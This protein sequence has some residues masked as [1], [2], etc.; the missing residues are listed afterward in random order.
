MVRGE[1]VRPGKARPRHDKYEHKTNAKLHKSNFEIIPDKFENN[2][3]FWKNILFSLEKMR[4][5]QLNHFCRATLDC[6][7]LPVFVTSGRPMERDQSGSG[8]SFPSRAS[9]GRPHSLTLLTFLQGVLTGI[10]YN[11]LRPLDMAHDKRDRT[12]LRG[13]IKP[14]K[15]IPFNYKD[16][17]PDLFV[18]SHSVIES[19]ELYI[20]D[21]SGSSISS[22]DCSINMKTKLN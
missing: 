14:L 22:L 8:A 17:N 3:K 18:D 6:V 9:S 21:G 4:K 16:L 7:Q 2:G 12:R 10:S 11:G 20:H 13:G 5:I 15:S 1:P 19:T